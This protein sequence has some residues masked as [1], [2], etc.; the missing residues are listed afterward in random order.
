MIMAHELSYRMRSTT[1]RTRKKVRIPSINPVSVPTSN[2]DALDIVKMTDHLR[3]RRNSDPC[4]FM[5]MNL[6]E[7]G[8]II[9]MWPACGQLSMNAVSIQADM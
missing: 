9:P 8:K 2:P 6:T 1:L 5:I 7:L 4:L 3:G